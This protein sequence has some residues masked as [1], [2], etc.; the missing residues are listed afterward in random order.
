MGYLTYSDSNWTLLILTN[1]LF[2]FQLIL[3]FTKKYNKK[4]LSKP[5][6]FFWL[7]VEIHAICVSNLKMELDRG[8]V[9]RILDTNL[10]Y[11]YSFQHPPKV[12]G[13]GA[14]WIKP[15]HTFSLVINDFMLRGF[16]S[17]S[18]SALYYSKKGNVKT[19][20]GF[21][22]KMCRHMSSSA[23]LFTKASNIEYSCA[24]VYVFLLEA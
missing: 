7:I 24:P 23:C 1:V 2:L 12:P 15:A 8:I 14:E 16:H 10:Y 5:H 3:N 6:K 21:E 4:P 20:P 17:D 13:W 18:E 19:P 9:I 22:L 11:N